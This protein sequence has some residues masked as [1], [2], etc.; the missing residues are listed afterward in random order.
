MQRICET[1]FN[2]GYHVTLIGRELKL[3]EPLK[4][5]TF[6]EKRLPCFFN[7]GFLFYF[8]YNIRVFLYLL[9]IKGDLFCAIDLD[10]ILPI[11]FI[12][13]IR[14][15]KR[16][17]DAHE[18]FTE[19]KEI[20]TRP[21][22]KFFWALIERSMVPKFQFG[23]TVN[24]FIKDEFNRK[25]K[26]E[27]AVI[28]NLPIYSTTNSKNIIPNKP[29]LIYQGAI[30]EGRS[31]ETLIPAMKE[32]PLHLKIFGQGNFLIQLKH[33]ITE[34]N[35]QDKVELCGPQ[36]PHTLK[37][38]TANAFAGLM[39]FENTGLNQYQSLANRFFD[40][41]MAGIPQVCVNYPQ[42]KLINDEFHIAHMI[43]DTK[44]VTISTAV[45]QLINN[46]KLYNDL[47]ENCKKAREIL[48]W[49]NEEI[50]L[51]HFYQQL[52]NN[53]QQESNYIE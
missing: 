25:Y 4:A 19:Q 21:L 14:N 20:V 3:S 2:A 38:F 44:P 53:N 8:E 35:L 47:Q 40:Y 28:R 41:I 46:D 52:L 50:T 27:Y 9:F 36:D 49:Q 18:L 31:F 42:Y 17:Y 29:Y 51:I 45:N 1:L 23:Y 30:N 15:K 5:N 10:T 11:Y 6:S 37:A 16:V 22:V 48:N 12:S 26:V 34:N 13:K 39:L 43:E 32:I 24:N 7:N 33:L